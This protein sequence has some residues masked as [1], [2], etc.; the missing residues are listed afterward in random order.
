MVFLKVL[1]IA[2]EVLC[3]FLLVGVIL[4]Q[5]T[6]NEGMGGLAF[7]S[8]VGETLFGSRAG[9]V[10]TKATITLSITFLVN[11]LLLAIILP[12][13]SSRSIIDERVG[14][15][16]MPAAAPAPA[17][18]PAPITGG[19]PLVAEPAPAAPAAAA[20]TL[21]PG[22]SLEDQP[23]AEPLVEQAPAAP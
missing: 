1:L 2:V 21:L 19:E 7:G 20:P 10:L 8:G 11:T 14:T 12:G 15:T 22:S 4:L 18:A 3:C 5:K 23:A 16:S 13:Q 6:K 9:N 17:P